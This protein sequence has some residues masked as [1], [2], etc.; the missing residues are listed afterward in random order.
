[1]NP[2]SRIMKEAKW[3]GKSLNG[4]DGNASSRKLT[5]LAM[6]LMFITTWFCELFFGM[7]VDYIMKVGIMSMIGI[8]LGFIT[9]QNLVDILKKPGSSIY[10]DDVIIPQGRKASPE[11]DSPQPD[12]VG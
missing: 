6:V 11:S 10:G 5:V 3:I 1:M 7:T 12:N 8:G 4:K 2:F 9:A